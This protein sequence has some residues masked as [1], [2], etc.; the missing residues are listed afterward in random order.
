[1]NEEI[2]NVTIDSRRIAV[3]RG[4]TILNACRA[5]GIQIPTLCHMDD[6]ST[7]AS[8]GICVVEV[9][10]SKRLV[11][12][13]TYA[14][15]NDMEIY[16]NTERVRKA[17][18]TNLELI[19][20]NHP[21][22]CLN[23]DRNQNCELQ[24]LAYTLGVRETRFPRT[25]AFE[26]PLDT[27]SVALIRD[28]NKCILCGRCVAV[29]AEMQTVHAI[30]VSGRGLESKVTTFLDKGLGNVACTNC[31]Q[32]ALVCPTGA[33]VE[34]SDVEAVWKDLSNPDLVTIVQ[35]APAIRVGIGEAMGMKEGALVTG[36]MV[37]G[38]RRLGFKK[39]FDT[40]FTAD[41]TIM[42]EGHEF[43]K[44]VST[45][46]TLPMITSCSPGWI[47]FIEHF[48]PEQLDH[49]STCK[50]PQ[51][52]FG[53]VAKTFYAEKTGIDP[54][55]LRVV[56]IMPCTAKK[57][58]AGRS[59]MDGAFH[60]WKEKL[61]LTEEERFADVDYALTTR[62]L[63]RM[64]KEIGISFE[65]LPEEAFDSPL[66]ASTGAAV[67]FGAT[68]G[69]MEAA[70]RTVYEVLTG[71]TLTQV[72]FTAVRGMDGIREATVDINGNPVRVAVGHTL[73]NARTLLEQIKAG[74]SPYAFIE[75]MTCPG[76]CLGGGGQPIPTTWEIRQKRA[77]SI[78][79]E[80]INLGI[81]KSH[82]NPEIQALYKDFLVEPLGE[83]SHHLLHTSY[84]A[85][86][87][88]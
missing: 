55:R 25:R 2:I 71:K 84:T 21:L 73:K 50:S 34:K 22:D 60:Y 38:L 42:E 54:R 51:Q 48:Y 53:A 58:E 7:N 27:S 56:S 4:T 37:A 6:V 45:G 65:H 19:L 47:K 15:W 30:D 13:C 81:R 39:V 29:C 24:S 64:F 85:R 16:T 66:G 28:P 9:K 3:K 83:H 59:E 67:I 77:Q 62:E 17:R 86:G 63:A 20:A 69:V 72:D 43:I 74:T 80:D 8:C 12:S 46:G 75:I 1:M 23:C 61:S 41:L 49:L 88:Y 33:I 44:R 32:C 68:G 87:V 76:G 78:Y 18:K 36:Q 79:Q 70:L 35:T 10:N 5:A 57:Y 26:L 31:G 11:R 14:V 52:M 82:E 40:Q